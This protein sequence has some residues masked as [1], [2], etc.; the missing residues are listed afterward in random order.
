MLVDPAIKVIES[1]LKLKKDKRL[2]FA[3][4]QDVLNRNGYKSYDEI[5]IKTSEPGSANEMNA[6]DPRE[7]LLSRINAQAEP[8]SAARSPEGADG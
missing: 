7:R 3:A 8:E 1:T 2:A 4:A 6:H 5:K